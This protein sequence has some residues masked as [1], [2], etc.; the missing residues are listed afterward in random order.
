MHKGLENMI[1]YGNVLMAWPK[2]NDP[3]N[4]FGMFV[5]CC[6]LCCCFSVHVVGGGL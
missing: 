4:V 6:F 2:S 5:C 3:I 1:N